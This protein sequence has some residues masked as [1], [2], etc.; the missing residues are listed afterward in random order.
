MRNDASLANQLRQLQIEREEIKESQL[1]G[2]SQLLIKETISEPITITSESRQYIS[3][4]YASCKVEAPSVT[5]NNVL[6]AYAVAEVYAEGGTL[7]D[8]SDPSEY[9]FHINSVRSD[10]GDTAGFQLTV[11]HSSQLGEEIPVENYSIRFHVWSAA[12][13]NLTVEEGPYG[14]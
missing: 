10:K 8:N 14:A 9:T 3:E 11:Y 5:G 6:I 13:V 2:K 12:T 7:V 1:V 4:A